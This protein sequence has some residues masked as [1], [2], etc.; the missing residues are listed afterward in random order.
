MR[1]RQDPYAVVDLQDPKIDF[2]VE[3]T[4]DI[5]IWD[6]VI[7]VFHRAVLIGVHQLGAAAQVQLRQRVAEALQDPELGIAG[8]VQLRQIAACTAKINEF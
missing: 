2:I 7:I 8:H 6:V 3:I 5:I 4:K 1:I